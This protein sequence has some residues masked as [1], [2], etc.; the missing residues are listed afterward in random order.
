MPEGLRSSRCHLHPPRD[1]DGSS[2]P[3][4]IPQDL[5][6]A[7]A[8]DRSLLQR[9]GTSMTGATSLGPAVPLLPSREASLAP[10]T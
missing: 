7:P 6:V 10:H 4:R 8:A 5:R 1:T 3:E 2:M 9:G